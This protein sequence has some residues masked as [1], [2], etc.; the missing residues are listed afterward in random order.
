MG[1]KDI[2]NES[3]LIQYFVPYAWCTNCQIP[4]GAQNLE[5]GS[6]DADSEK[7]MAENFPTTKSTIK[8][9]SISYT[10]KII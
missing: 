7:S 1:I 3:T 6:M 4:E 2:Q 9:V 10:V 5:E 8:T